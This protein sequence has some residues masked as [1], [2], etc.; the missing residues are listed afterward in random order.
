MRDIS[1]ERSA[2][3]SLSHAP[4]AATNNIYISFDFLGEGEGEREKKIGQS[5]IQEAIKSETARRQSARGNAS[6][7][8]YNIRLC[9]RLTGRIV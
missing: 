1:V 7:E 9:A 5:A 4:P 8:F 2:P 3:L 6:R